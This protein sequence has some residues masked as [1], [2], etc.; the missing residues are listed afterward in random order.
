MAMGK[1]QPLRSLETLQIFVRPSKGLIQDKTGGFFRF[2]LTT[3]QQ[4]W[5]TNNPKRSKS[6]FKHVMYHWLYQ[7]T[8]LLQNTVFQTISHTDGIVVSSCPEG[9]APTAATRRKL[10]RASGLPHPI[11]VS[12]SPFYLSI[13]QG[14][15][16]GCCCCC[17]CC[18][19]WEHRFVSLGDISSFIAAS[20]C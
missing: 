16:V 4:K 18:C 2:Q 14:L 13:S 1:W 11:A 12:T 15:F 5:C 9:V 8:T 10:G 6:C 20:F 3:F 17:C 7:K 19:C